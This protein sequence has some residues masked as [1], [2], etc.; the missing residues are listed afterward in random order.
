[1]KTLLITG[2]VIAYSACA[3]AADDQLTDIQLDS[4]TAGSA[5]ANA[6]ADAI[7]IIAATT[8][9]T[10]AETRANGGQ[11]TVVNSPARNAASAL[12][13]GSYTPAPSGG[14]TGGTPGEASTSQSSSSAN[15]NV[16]PTTPTV[17]VSNLTAAQ[18]VL[19]GVR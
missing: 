15:T 11:S 9:F 13:S 7:G 12:L 2:L 4:V 19:Q 1:M 18:R 5:A 10:F 16:V 3:M 6:T 8:T 14:S 17:P